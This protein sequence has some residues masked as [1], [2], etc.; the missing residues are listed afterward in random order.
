[1]KPRLQ[2]H[3]QH[4]SSICAAL[5]AFVTWTWLLTVPAAQFELPP[6]P[7]LPIRDGIAEGIS[8]PFSFSLLVSAEILLLHGRYCASS[9]HGG[10]LYCKIWGYHRDSLAVV[11]HTGPLSP[12]GSQ[13]HRISDAIALPSAR[14]CQLPSSDN[15]VLTPFFLRMS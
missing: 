1:M 2:M 12:P 5:L 11:C 13:R 8:Y 9:S 6:C 7:A 3:S 14:T 4:M 10:A 15:A